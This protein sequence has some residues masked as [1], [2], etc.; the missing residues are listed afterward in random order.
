MA[1]RPGSVLWLM[2]HELRLLYRGTTRKFRNLLWVVLVF[3]TFHLAAIPLA[4]GMGFFA[5]L[6]DVI[7]LLLV[8]GLVVLLG[9]TLAARSLTLAVQSLYERGD[10]DLLLSSPLDGR[11]LFSVRT[12]TLVVALCYELGVLV[13]PFANVFA[14]FGQLRWLCAYLALPLAAALAISFSLW[15]SFA[16]VRWLGP[17]PT[18][19]VAQVLAGVVGI[20]AASATQIPRL[21][22]G[23]DSLEW[24]AS[25]R[26]LASLPAQS[27]PLWIPARAVMGDPLWTPLTAAFCL[28]IFAWSV[29]RL[30]AEFIEGLATT[31]GVAPKR[32]ARGA[33]I[34]RFR[35]GVYTALARKELR[36]LLRD[37][38]LVTQL[39]QQNVYLLPMMFVFARLKLHGLSC[40]WLVVIVC[41]GS[42]ASAFAWL[43]AS[44]E[45]APELL[46]TAPISARHLLLAQLSAS[47]LPVLLAA[48]ACSALL[49]PRD[50]LAAGVLFACSAGNALCNALLHLR[51]KR[52]AKRQ[53]FLRR[54]QHN[55]PLLLAELVFLAGW[56]GVA[57]LLL[58]LL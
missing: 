2:R 17:R 15:V 28:G 25:P 37:P 55:L 3:G 46:G 50:P 36:L 29:W 39:L 18:R 27:S 43:A 49:A 35:S 34:L 53:E 21:V 22:S 14:A 33:R 13:L 52:P 48:A 7:P 16:L 4:S 24:L 54:N 40:I 47:V 5:K 58:A 45:E 20:C 31:A 32:P 10:M 38:W 30:G 1:L 51:V 8:S 56:V 9:L 42:T 26:L 6:S 19:L 12:S 11:T 23:H 41:A 44:G 57:V